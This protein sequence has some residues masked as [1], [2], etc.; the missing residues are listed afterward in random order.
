MAS[1]HEQRRINRPNTWQL[2]PAVRYR[3]NSLDN[4]EPSTHGTKQSF[5]DHNRNDRF[6][7]LSGSSEHQ[8]LLLGVERT[9][10]GHRV[11]GCC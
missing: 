5:S 8:C 1:G 2:R 9:E 7:V 6:G 4:T 3:S 10:I 11:F